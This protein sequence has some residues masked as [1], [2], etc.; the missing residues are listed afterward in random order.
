MSTNPAPPSTPLVDAVRRTHT[1][2]AVATPGKPGIAPGAAAGRQSGASFARQTT[3]RTG[4]KAHPARRVTRIA[5]LVGLLA[6]AAMWLSGNGGLAGLLRGA[7]RA[8]T[9]LATTNSAAA[10]AL[11]LLGFGRVRAAA[12]L[13]P[14]CDI[15]HPSFLY[16]FAALKVQIGARMGDPLECER[17]I[18]P[19]GDTHQLTTTGL[20][21]YRNN[22]NI[23]SFVDGWDHWALTE[24]G[25]VHWIGD[26]VDP[27][28]TALPMPTPAP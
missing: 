13:P 12:G 7:D 28:G 4:R 1:H 9:E 2:E 5:I 24:R 20:A 11:N 16:G 19:S 23:P 10:D 26:V 17:A 8:A 25:L 14:I 3:W 22:V 18:H 21:Y 6:A 27:P 15:H